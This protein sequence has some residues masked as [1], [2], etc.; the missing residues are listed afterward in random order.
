L[1]DGL[2][3]ALFL[4]PSFSSFTATLAGAVAFALSVEIDISFAGGDGRPPV[5]SPIIAELDCWLL[6]EFL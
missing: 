5:V 4:P 1:E 6:S 2:S 3:F